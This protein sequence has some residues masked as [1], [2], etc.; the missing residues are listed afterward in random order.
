M[1]TWL[2][3]LLLF[4]SLGFG[5][6]DADK[7]AYP[8]SS[9]LTAEMI[10]QAGITRI[11]DLFLLLP[12]WSVSSIDGYS[13]QVSAN[14]LSSLQ[15]QSWLVFLDGHKL[16]LQFMDFNHINMM[17]VV[18]DNID[19]VEVV[20]TPQMYGG[21]FVEK[22]MI[23]IHTLKPPRGISMTGELLLGNETGDPGPY[24]FTK[25]ATTNLDRIA[26]DGSMSLA[27]G[28]R[29]GYAR[30]SL[31]VHQHPF[32]DVAMLRRNTAMIDDWP[33]LHKAISPSL[34]V[35]LNAF[36]GSH[37]AFL[38]YPS[39]FRYFYFFK[40]L[41]RE[42]PVN[43]QLPQLGIRGDLAIT[44]RTT[45]RYRVAASRLHLEP[46][47]DAHVQNFRW[48][49]RH[50]HTN[51]EAVRQGFQC[52]AHIGGTY[53]RFALETDGPL[54]NEAYNLFRLFG[55]FSRQPSKARAHTLAAM[56]VSDG[57]SAALKG[58]VT[59]RWG[60]REKRSARINLSYSQ[61]LFQED[62]SLW[63]WVDQGID[64]LETNGIEYT[65][66]GDFSPSTQF[67]TDLVLTFRPGRQ[68]RIEATGF[69]RAFKGL[70][71]A[72]QDFVFNPEDHSVSSPLV[73]VYPDSKGQVWGIRWATEYQPTLTVTHRL[74]GR[75][76]GAIP[77]DD[78]FRDKW[79]TIPTFRASYQFTYKPSASFSIWAI[80]RYKS[81]SFWRE[82]RQIDGQPYLSTFKDELCYSSTVP[83]S[84]VIDFKVEKSFWNKRLA[85]GIILRNLLHQEHR[86]HPLGASFDFSLFLQA[87]LLLRA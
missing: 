29:F 44:T 25:Y 41:G 52:Q 31:V 59:I 57:K 7:P 37:E 87:K 40:P 18:L 67:T 38:G 70:Y 36:G 43:S 42:I 79:A 26:N 69:H 80:A 19:Y 13:W 56:V 55:M 66:T 6:A 20:S 65:V 51:I 73:E 72:T 48:R 11:G 47:E 16:D 61:R 86:Y 3:T 5:I 53:D 71:G 21:E 75:F 33:G 62:N 35:G 27:W 78:H 30:G 1:R 63:Y 9:I 85:L 8:V 10:R 84:T 17:P 68:L 58:A 24:R 15:D 12:D 34:V 4:L 77:G 83:S 74:F 14:G 81:A 82:Y 49:T 39:T 2:L 22:G 23:H 54:H 60:S 50:L 32:T 46:H 28:T 64:I 76:Q 45:V